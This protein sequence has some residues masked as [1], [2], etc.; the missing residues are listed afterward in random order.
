MRIGISG[1]H[2]TGKTT[3]AEALCAL[4]HH[5]FI[6]AEKNGTW[7]PAIEVPGISGL[8]AEVDAEAEAVSCA[9]PGN[10]GAGGF[11][12]DASLHLQ[13]FVVDQSTATSTA[14][15]LSAAKIRSGYEQAEKL[16]VQVKARTSGTPGGTVT[17]TA[18]TT[19]YL[20]DHPR[21]RQGNLHAEGQPAPPRQPSAHRHVRRQPGLQQVHFGQTD[22]DRD[23]VAPGRAGQ[24]PLTP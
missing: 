12:T 19:V 22:A 18:G 16:T 6:S 9:S 17:V 20:R 15:T 4:G 21:R 24:P 1:T 2:G 11:S 10:C 14:L 5:P 8:N 23:E 3:L 13:A 7:Q